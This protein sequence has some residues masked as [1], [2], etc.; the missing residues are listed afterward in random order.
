[1]GLMAISRTYLMPR[2]PDVKL[3]GDGGDSDVEPVIVSWWHLLEGGGLGKV[4]PLWYADLAGFLQESGESGDKVTLVDILDT[5]HG[6][7]VFTILRLDFCK[8][9][10]RL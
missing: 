3:S 8:F 2:C 10:L 7:I 1:M 4:A 6:K 5:H 9:D